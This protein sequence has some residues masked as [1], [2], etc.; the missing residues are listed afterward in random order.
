MTLFLSRARLRS[1][2]S[3]GGIASALTDVGEG[4]PL[5]PQRRLLWTLFADREDR[6][7]DFLW[8]A[9]GRRRFYLLSHRPP[10]DRH[11][12]FEIESKAFEP[13]LAPG[14]RLAFSLRV[15]ATKD[16]AAGKPTKSVTSPAVSGDRRVDIV[17]DALHDLK[18]DARRN[19]RDESAHSAAGAWLRNQGSRAGFTLESVQVAAYDVATV[20]RRRGKPATFGILD[21]TGVLAV[22]APETFLAKLA[23]G[24][25]RAKA[26]GNGLMLIR[27]A[28]DR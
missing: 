5:N 12:L 15:N 7:R 21:L 3:V 11:A 26:F 28:A 8:R 13:A 27:R 18:G 23:T 22:D 6:E 25:G 20:P 4:G 14:D 24:F 17:M 10:E 9:D 2:P 1:D 16:R 19:A